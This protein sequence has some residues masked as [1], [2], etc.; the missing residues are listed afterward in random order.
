MYRN[1]SKFDNKQFTLDLCISLRSSLI[2]QKFDSFTKV[3]QNFSSF[4]NIFNECLNRHAPLKIASC[5]KM[6]LKKNLE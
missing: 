1:K 6:K 3:D 4:V 5:K 2:K